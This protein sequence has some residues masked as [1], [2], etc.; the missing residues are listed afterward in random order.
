MRLFRLGAHHKFFLW[1]GVVFLGAGVAVWAGYRHLEQQRLLLEQK[2]RPVL[3][4]RV[5]AAQDL[6]AGTVLHEMHLAVRA[7]PQQ[8]IPADSV[9]PE[10]YTR[11]LGMVLRGPI[12]AG[13]MVLGVHTVAATTEHFSARLANGRR[14]VTMPVDQINAL[15]GLLRAGDLVDLYVSFDHQR[16]KVTAPLLQGVLVLA[17]DDS[18]DQQGGTGSYATVTLDLSPEDG[19]KLVAARQVGMIT[20]ML[21]N[22]HDMHLSDKAV[23]G[24]LATLLGLSTSATEFKS[25]PVI[26]GNK[27]PRQ[28]RATD[29]KP[30]AVRE[31]VVTI[32]TAEQLSYLQE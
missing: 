32:P 31:A 23:R 7:F 5:V 10:Q 3:I 14:A 11:L 19:A 2:N 28:I 16:R 4:E 22:P 1:A 30:A 12:K 9:T 24:D 17:T 20:A 29:A 18:T 21:R 13:D 15:A 26:Y 6:P 8:S 27:V 25:V